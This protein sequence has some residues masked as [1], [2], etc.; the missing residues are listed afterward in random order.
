MSQNHSLYGTVSLAENGSEQRHHC[1]DAVGDQKNISH[2]LGAGAESF[3]NV[4]G[5]PG[6]DDDGFAEDID[7]KEHDDLHDYA[8]RAGSETAIS[9]EKGQYDAHSP[10]CERPEEFEQED[11]LG[12]GLSINNCPDSYLPKKII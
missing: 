11:K 1:G 7:E 3:N 4:I 2:G 5:H 9:Q 12:V 10:V 8:D 6:I